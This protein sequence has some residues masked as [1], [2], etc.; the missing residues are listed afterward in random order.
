VFT[1]SPPKQKNN[2]QHESPSQNKKT[3]SNTDPPPETNNDEQHGFP[4]EKLFWEGDPCC[5]LFF[6]LGGGSVLLIVFFLG[7]GFVLVMYISLTKQKRISNTDP[8][9]KIKNDEQHGSP[10]KTKKN[11]SNT[12]NPLKTKIDEQHGSSFQNKK[13]KAT[14]IPLPKQNKTMVPHV[15]LLWERIRT[16]IRFFF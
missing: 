16:A 1:D 11:M 15:F 5:P 2:D 14:R 8:L 3:M 6:V 7:G 9:A 4:S 12:D 13:R 10:P